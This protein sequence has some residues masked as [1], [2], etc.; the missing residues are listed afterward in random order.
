MTAKVIVAATTQSAILS[1]CER[2]LSWPCTAKQQR[3][4]EHS[5]VQRLGRQFEFKTKPHLH[6]GNDDGDGDGAHGAISLS[7][8]LAWHGAAQPA[9][10]W[11][12]AIV[13]LRSQVLTEFV[14]LE[15]GGD[16]EE[17]ADGDPEDAL[18]EHPESY[19]QTAAELARADV[20]HCCRSSCET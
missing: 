13:V 7:G 18:A 16:G 1:L 15:P 17:P 9:S 11:C 8:S 20:R 10:D 14:N 19:R 2:S 12:V 4:T 5:S 6:R 3:K